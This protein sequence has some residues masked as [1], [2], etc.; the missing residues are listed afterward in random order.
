MQMSSYFIIIIICVVLVLMVASFPTLL[1]SQTTS[2]L[3]CTRRNFFLPL[4]IKLV[5]WMTIA[6]NNKMIHSNLSM[7]EQLGNS[8]APPQSK[9]FSYLHVV[10]LFL[11]SI[12]NLF[13]LL[14]RHLLLSFFSFPLTLRFHVYERIRI[15]TGTIIPQIFFNCK[16][17]HGELLV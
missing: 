5:Q 17:P 12:F 8:F 10:L 9:L 2:L 16:A 11:G 14:L 3:L 15:G 7:R 13:L 1:W 6:N 4:K